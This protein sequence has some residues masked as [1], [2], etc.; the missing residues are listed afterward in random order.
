M[1]GCVTISFVSRSRRQ[2][3]R[4]RDVSTRVINTVR[5]FCDFGAR[6]LCDAGARRSAGA[7]P[8]QDVLDPLAVKISSDKVGQ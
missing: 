1:I 4:G 3:H 6:G 7:S 8:R 5:A 2:S